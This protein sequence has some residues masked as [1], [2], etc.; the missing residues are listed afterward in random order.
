MERRLAPVSAGSASCEAC[1]ASSTA[2]SARTRCNTVRATATLPMM[3]LAVPGRWGTTGRPTCTTSEGTTC[4]RRLSTA[5]LSSTRAQRAV[6]PWR[7]APSTRRNTLW[8]SQ[9]AA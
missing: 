5:G 4:A 3:V 2:T 8:A 1:S 9:R 6:R 7:T